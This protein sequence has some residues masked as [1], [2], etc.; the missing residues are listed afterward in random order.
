[1]SEDTLGKIESHEYW[2]GL[3]LTQAKSAEL[4]DEV[5]V[6]AIVVRDGKLIGQGFNR[7]IASCDPTAHAEIQ[8]IREAARGENNYRLSGATLYVTIEPCA[9]CVGAIVHARITTVVF[10]AR[11]PKAGALLSQLELGSAEHF[12][13]KIEIVEGVMAEQCRSIMQSF[14]KSKRGKA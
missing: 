7:P 3:A 5:P 8:A 1:M 4:E 2:M 11:E 10:G 9:M 6:G 13:H 14:F 12:N